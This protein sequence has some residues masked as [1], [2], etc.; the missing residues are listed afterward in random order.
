LKQWWDNDG[1][2]EAE[3]RLAEK[4]VS[5]KEDSILVNAE[6]NMDKADFNPIYNPIDSF[7][8][9]SLASVFSPVKGKEN[10]SSL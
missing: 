6:S 2:I 1:K 7:D 3:K 9:N 10:T 4:L 5:G 8:F